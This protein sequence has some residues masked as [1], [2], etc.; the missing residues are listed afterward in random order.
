MADVILH[1][2]P[3]FRERYYEIRRKGLPVVYLIPKKRSTFY[4]V[5]RVGIGS[6]DRFYREGDAIRPVIC[7][8]AH[9][10][11]HKLFAN[12][13]GSDA[14]E[15]LR[16][17]GADANAY[18]VGTSTCY[19]FNCRDN[20]AASL[21]ELLSFVSQPCFT[22]EN[23]ELEKKIILQ[24][25]AMYVD[26][27]SSR[28]TRGALRQLYRE[29][30]IR[31]E[32]VGTPGT[33]RRITPAHLLRVYRAFYHAD[34]MQLFVAGDLTPEDVLSA[35]SGVEMP[36]RDG[37]FRVPPP[38]ESGD[39]VSSV[40]VFS[41][42]VSKPLFAVS[43][44]FPEP[45]GSAR[46]KHLEM[47]ALSVVNAHLFGTSGA[48][49]NDLKDR[50]LLTAPLRCV[51][52][53]NPG[54]CFV[55]ASGQSASPKK[56]YEEIRAE[57]RLLTST[58]ISDADVSRLVRAQ[59][60]EEVASFDDVEDLVD[61]FC[62]VIPDGV[63]PFEIASLFGSVTTEYVNSVL[64]KYYA[65]DRLNLTVIRPDQSNRQESEDEE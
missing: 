17:L 26:S 2:Y 9:F 42:R 39:P 60:A 25:A 35:L 11:E 7:G 55:M 16:D 3:A 56:V 45:T 21:S 53:W 27:P 64:Q 59:Y 6:Y 23:V 19:L 31:D 34:N 54:V 12:P 15:R 10:L 22:R 43:S 41:R 30:P 32:I 33:I 38:S 58:G 62:E 49:Y 63:D 44:A 29:H 5:L 14:M 57:I 51:A 24:E 4:A 36:T 13:D 37:A 28:L 48:L 65:G 61:E 46:D 1:D 20:F 40:R 50:G 52:E 47:L 8:T 18:T